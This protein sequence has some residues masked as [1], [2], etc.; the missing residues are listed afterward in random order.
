MNSKRRL[1]ISNNPLLSGPA[2]SDRDRIGIPYRVIQLSAIDS[3]P[4]Q[5][6][7]DFDNEKLQ[8]L[9]DSIR[10][11]GVLS[12]ILVRPGPISGRYTIISGERR[13]RAAKL[14]GLLEVPAL[15][16]QKPEGGEDRTLALQLV[17]NLQRADLT[18]LERAQA[19]GALRD[20]YQ[21]SVR[22]IADRLGISK[23]KVQRTLQFLELPDDLMNALK[24]GV[25]ETKVLLLAEIEDPA[26][27]A[28]YL[29]DIDSITRDDL[30]KGV[31]GNKETREGDPLSAED[32]RIADEIQ[33]AI[34]LRV[35]LSRP[36]AGS[37]AGRLIIDF[38]SSSDL[39]EL[40]R[41]LVAEQR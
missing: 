16:D 5:P 25:A 26:I 12:P 39:Q 20:S 9:S 29:K 19:I 31:R 7:R 32:R 38:Y 41:R 35:K 27:R 14:A 24:A 40:F 4:T 8:E 21:L 1:V 10:M 22:D 23:S 36:T 13:Y 15:I 30:Q 37:D 11:Y 18:P 34:G 2:L 33:R 17:E 6:R 3:D 28:S